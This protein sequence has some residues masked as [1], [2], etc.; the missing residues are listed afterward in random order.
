[1]PRVPPGVAYRKSPAAFM[2]CGCPGGTLRAPCHRRLHP[3]VREERHELE[4]L[5]AAVEHI[6]AHHER[7]GTPDPGRI[8]RSGLPRDETPEPQRL[9]ARVQVPVDVAHRHHPR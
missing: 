6:P 7:R 8:A 5:V 9:H 3:K 1:M 2:T 4:L